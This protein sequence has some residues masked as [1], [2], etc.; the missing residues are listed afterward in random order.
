MVVLVEAVEST[1]RRTMRGCGWEAVPSLKY[2]SVPSKYTA[3]LTGLVGAVPLGIFRLSLPVVEAANVTLP[4]R[5]NGFAIARTG[6]VPPLEVI[7]LVVPVTEVTQVEHVML[8]VEVV[9]ARGELAVTAG[10]P[11]LV[12]RVIVGVPAAACG[13]MMAVPLV[14]PTNDKV[15]VVPDAPRVGLKVQ[16][17]RVPFAVRIWPDEPIR[18]HFSGLT[19]SA[20]SASPYTIPP[21]FVRQGQTA[22][23]WALVL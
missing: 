6:V 11:L 15:P 14:E 8:P 5:V 12:P 20:L 2:S 22:K 18:R 9:M 4:G 13:V 1:E 19:F 16:E 17:G 21:T 10:V 23:S 3:P 7:W